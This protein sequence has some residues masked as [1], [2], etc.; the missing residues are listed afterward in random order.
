MS[1]W[2]CPRCGA[3]LRSAEGQLICSDPRC[4]RAFPI[5]GGIP[6]LINE[7]RSVFPIADFVSRRATT[8]DWSRQS[9]R[10]SARGL[11]R[12][13]QRGIAD[14]SPS[15]TLG[16]NEFTAHDAVREILKVRPGAKILVIGCGAQ[17][18][19]PVGAA[20]FVYSDVS[21]GPL[22]QV[23]FDATDIPYPDETFDAV[24]SVAVIPYVSDPYRCV[25]EITRVLCPG[26]FVYDTSAFM[27]QVHMGRFDYTR[28]TYM[29]HRR[30]FRD[31][32]AVQRGITG[33]PAM[34]LCWSISYFVES[35]SDSPSWR[36]LAR[37]GCRYSLFWLKYFDRLLVRR[38]GAY[39]AASGFFLFGRKREQPLN[40]REILDSHV[41]LRPR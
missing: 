20:C 8:F 7:D 12:T 2:V 26:G 33:G 9:A 11:L 28:F 14:L 3:R 15:L 36:R 10:A 29:G 5:V 24:L 37:L 27:Q 23:V 1:G 18:F 16:V 32:D 34:A 13:L 31:F 30:L 6:I 35:L 4:S 22:T 17:R 40:D 19:S 21:I 41:G 25:A 38:R 39:D